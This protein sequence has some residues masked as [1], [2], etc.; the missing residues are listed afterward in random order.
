MVRTYQ[1]CSPGKVQVRKVR[2]GRSSPHSHPMVGGS[3]ESGSTCTSKES[4]FTSLGKLV[5]VVM[6]RVR[7]V[8]V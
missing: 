1:L 4:W 3:Q 5:R 6:L 2:L 7:W 8:D